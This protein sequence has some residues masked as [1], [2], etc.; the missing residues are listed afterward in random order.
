MVIY[1]FN[2]TKIG[3]YS[4]FNG[5]EKIALGTHDIFKYKCR[6][7]SVEKVPAVVR[8]FGGSESPWKCK[9]CKI[10]ICSKCYEIDVKDDKCPKCG[11]KVH[12]PILW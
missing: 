10:F 2:D 5:G 7:C 1:F 12:H 9:K 11:G 6:I 8:G 3:S 4:H